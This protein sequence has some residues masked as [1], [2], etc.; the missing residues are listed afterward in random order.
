V[1]RLFGKGR[2]GLGW[3]SAVNPGWTGVV[4]LGWTGVDG[5]W[6]GRPSAASDAAWSPRG[7]SAA[8]R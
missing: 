3:T 4:N 7:R 1:H 2:F 8:S 6:T 5:V